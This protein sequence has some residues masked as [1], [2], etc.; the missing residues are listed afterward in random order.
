MQW[1]VS[2]DSVLTLASSTIPKQRRVTIDIWVAKAKFNV[3]E[4]R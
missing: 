4:T 1:R 2:G 3:P